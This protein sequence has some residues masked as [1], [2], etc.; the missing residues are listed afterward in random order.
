M[1]EEIT[2]PAKSKR[3]LSPYLIVLMGS[4]ITSCIAMNL[5]MARYQFGIF[6]FWKTLPAPPAKVESIIG[7]DTFRNLW[8][9]SKD[10]KI[11]FRFI[12]VYFGDCKPISGCAW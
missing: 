2:S 10:G 7:V 3:E 8:V 11:Y 6:V 9:K 12:E 4:F 1:T 5:V